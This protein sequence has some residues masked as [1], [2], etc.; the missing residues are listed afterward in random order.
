MSMARIKVIL[1]PWRAPEDGDNVPDDLVIKRDG[2]DRNIWRRLDGT[3]VLVSIRH[4]PDSAT[5][6]YLSGPCR[7]VLWTACLLDR[8]GNRIAM[9]GIP[10]M[11]TY[12]DAVSAVTDELVTR[13]WRKVMYE[14]AAALRIEAERIE[15]LSR[16]GSPDWRML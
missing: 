15:E 4:C 8:D 10:G 7:E 1:F 13:H 3:I 9:F 14:R 11:K 16:T 5:T 12:E 2:T 6:F